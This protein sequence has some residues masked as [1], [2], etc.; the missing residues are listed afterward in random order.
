VKTAFYSVVIL[1]GFGIVGTYISF[2][3]WQ[4]LFT[5]DTIQDFF[6]YGS[7]KCMNHEKVQDLLGKPI[8]AYLHMR[9][10]YESRR[11]Y[12][13]ASQK[14]KQVEHMYYIDESGKMGLRIQFDLIGLRRQ[15]VGELDAREDDS[16]KLQTR[17]IIV[18]TTDRAVASGG[19][20][21]P[22]VFGQRVNPI[23]TRGADYTHHSATRPPEFSDLATG[24]TDMKRNSVIV[25]DNR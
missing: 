18:T 5:G 12:R 16:G 14:S 20:L 15:A 9:Y 23:S 1:A 22:P 13:R 4:M 8:N 3:G 17:Y 25:E 7:D 24:L 21:A 10:A 2:C 6:Q 19:A 11:G